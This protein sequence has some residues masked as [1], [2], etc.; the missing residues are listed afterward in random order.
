MPARPEPADEPL[1]TGFGRRGRAAH[2]EVVHDLVERPIGVVGEVHR[3]GEGG[4]RRPG[5]QGQAV[6]Q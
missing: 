6:H 4:V 3:A 5:V 1:G 2:V